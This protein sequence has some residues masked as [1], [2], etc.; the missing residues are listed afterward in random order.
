MPL[1]AIKELQAD[2]DDMISSYSKRSLP[3]IPPA[4]SGYLSQ[5]TKQATIA[6][7]SSSATIAGTST[8]AISH[9]LD[10]A[11]NNTADTTVGTTIS[12]PSKESDDDDFEVIV[13][14]SWDWADDVDD[15]RE[16]ATLSPA[17]GQVAKSEIGARSTTASP[18]FSEDWEHLHSESVKQS[19]TAMAKAETLSDDDSDWSLLQG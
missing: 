11:I 2:L 15:A 1:P 19:P 4:L 6:G 5:L 18:S 17:N 12:A 13:K 16:D 7:T 3:P 9:A 8:S 10:K 14:S